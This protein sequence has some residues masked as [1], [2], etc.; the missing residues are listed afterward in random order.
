[1]RGFC[2]D[3]DWTFHKIIITTHQIYKYNQNEAVN[4]IK[5]RLSQ[6]LVLALIFQW[7]NW[8]LNV[9]SLVEWFKFKFS[10]PTSGCSSNSQSFY[11]LPL[12]VNID[13]YMC[14][15]V[16]LVQCHPYI[17]G[18]PKW[19]WGALSVMHFL[20]LSWFGHSNDLKLHYV[21][22]PTNRGIGKIQTY[23]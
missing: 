18:R 14:V 10:K 3:W 12:S 2:V 19:L 6:S 5:S 11:C 16:F 4:V 13:V 20:I 15:F 17:F 9:Q 1:M 22:T 7:F 23:P 8:L 21:T